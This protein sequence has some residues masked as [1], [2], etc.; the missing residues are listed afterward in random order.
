MID[1]TVWIFCRLLTD[2]G[3]TPGIPGNTCDCGW[4]AG[5]Y[6]CSWCGAT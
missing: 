4:D 5:P 3:P 6:W 1:W 2:R